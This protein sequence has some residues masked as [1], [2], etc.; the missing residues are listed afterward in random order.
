L[1]LGTSTTN[2]VVTQ[3]QL[4]TAIEQA[5]NALRQLIYANAGT[6]GQ[7]Q[8]STGGYTNNLAISQRID[9]LSNVT[10]SNATVHGVSGLAAT[11]IPDLSSQYLPLSG[12]TVTGGL[13]VT[14]AFSGGSISLNTASS[15]NA[16]FTNATT[17][18]SGEN[19]R[20]RISGN[21]NVGI[22]T[23]TPYSRL[24]VWGPNT[25]SS[26]LAFN[27]VNNASTTV[28]AVFDGG[29][30]QLSGTLTQSSD[31][32]LKTNIQSL[33]AS[34][35]LAAINSLTPVA[36]NWLDPNKD[37][38]RQ[39]GFIAQQVQQVF[40]NLVSTTSATALTPD[41]TLGLNYIGLIAPIVEAVQTLSA[42]V[43]TLTSTVRS[44]A[45]SFTTKIL[46]ANTGN[47]Q[48][49]CVQKSDGTSVCVNGDQLAGI[50]SGTPSVQISA[51][52]TP[53][54]SGTT[55]PPSISIQGNNPA[56]INVGDTYTDLGAIV[57]DNQGHDLSYRTFIN[58]VLSGNILIDTS[59]VATDTIDYVATDTWGNTSTSTRT[60]IVESA[61]SSPSI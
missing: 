35:S 10:I 20:L 48:K 23:T 54:I 49:L 58:G 17:Y 21:G 7:G 2:G 57:H 16:T 3:S 19:E 32:R 27:I 12:G 34:T 44:F 61:S 30:A 43:Q 9:S 18:A 13:T 47:F 33:D 55:T 56:T 37:G 46:T 8:Y 60:I 39:Y 50:L 22:G 25:A 5:S 52:T 6:V 41:G 26:T 38:T 24:T 42:E 40:P 14:G 53:T 31:A 29:N 11:D 36:Y 59:Q 4:Q 51:P 15:T 28:F 45:D 1:I